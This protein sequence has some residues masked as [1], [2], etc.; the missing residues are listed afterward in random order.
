MRLSRSCCWR[1]RAVVRWRA[2]QLGHPG[3]AEN[4]KHE[5]YKRR[6]F[7]K[8]EK[9][10]LKVPYCHYPLGLQLIRLQEATLLCSVMSC[11]AV[12]HVFTPSHVAG[13][14]P[15]RLRK[16]NSHSIPIMSISM[17]L[18][19]RNSYAKHSH[20]RCLPILTISTAQIVKIPELG[21]S[22]T[23]IVSIC[24]DNSSLNSAQVRETQPSLLWL[25]VTSTYP[26]DSTLKSP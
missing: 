1:G 19:Q 2:I 10:L 20:I 13:S 4:S 3:K 12:P 16:A 11:R 23:S 18:A 7:F 26:N 22:V 15:G 14:S 25:D 8:N 9:K 21:I 17:A 6:I 24:S 5:H